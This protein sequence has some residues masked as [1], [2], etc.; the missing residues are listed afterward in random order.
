MKQILLISL[1][2]FALS[3][4][5]TVK[6][7]QRERSDYQH[8]AVV[9]AIRERIDSIYLHQRDSIYIRERGDTV[10]VDRWR[11]TTMYRDRLRTD[12]LR[13]VDSV[14]VEVIKEVQ[15]VQGQS[16]WAAFERYC[17]RILLVALCLI[18]IYLFLKW[19][20]KF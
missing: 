8:T 13:M 17:G 5:C 12:T 18:G 1:C 14:R 6:E 16:A 7:V 20:L 3:G 9:A 4:C 10:L 11:T 19:R 2:A 15:R